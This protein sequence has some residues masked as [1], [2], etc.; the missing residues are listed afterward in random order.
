MLFTLLILLCNHVVISRH[1]FSSGCPTLGEFQATTYQDTKGDLS[2]SLARVPAEKMNIAENI[3]RRGR[4][5]NSRM[6]YPISGFQDQ[7]E[8]S[9]PDS[10]NIQKDV[11]TRNRSDT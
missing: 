11:E 4:D 6:S 3:W 9:A 2:C 1:A 7:T 5:L 10:S 8:P